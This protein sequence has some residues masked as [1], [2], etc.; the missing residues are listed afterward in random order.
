MKKILIVAI[1]LM[2]F[3]SCAD[4]TKKVPVSDS[5]KE[6]ITTASYVHSDEAISVDSSEITSAESS[7][8]VPVGPSE[9]TSANTVE[10]IIKMP[11]QS[12]IGVWSTDEFKT[13]Q[14]LIYEITAVSVKFNTGVSG[15]FGFDATAM[16]SDDEIIFGDGVS[17][18][19]GGPDGLKGR[20]EFS[21][22]SITVIYDDLG[23]I[24]YSEYYPNR[25]TFTVKD[26]NSD[27]IVS[28]YKEH[29]PD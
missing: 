13:D 15:L 6:D 26:E 2:M 20:L 5:T 22:N 8:T 11:D 24:E 25:Y 21:E 9:I 4:T 18:G 16:L 14:I 7:E 29:I 19:Y 27:A 28:Q 10:D 17:P 23:S 12:F 1:A 3:C